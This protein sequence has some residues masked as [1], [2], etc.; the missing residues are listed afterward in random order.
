ML[1]GRQEG[2]VRIVMVTGFE[3]FNVG[4]YQE[5]AR[6]L[7]ATCPQAELL[8]FSDR[9]DWTSIVRPYPNPNLE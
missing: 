4:L 2:R 3:S 9:G 8:V 7:A 6:Q 5:V 1:L